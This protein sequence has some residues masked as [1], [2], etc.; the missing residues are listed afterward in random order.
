MGLW[1]SWVALLPQ[2]DTLMR[3]WIAMGWVHSS[4]DLGLAFSHIWESTRY[5]N[6]SRMALVV[7]KGVQ[8]NTQLSRSPGLEWHTVTS[9]IFYWL[10][11]S[12]SPD[13]FKGWENR[14]HLLMRRASM[15]P[16]KEYGH[17]EM[18]RTGKFGPQTATL[19]MV[20]NPS[21]SSKSTLHASI[22]IE[23]Q[24]AMQILFHGLPCS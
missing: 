5:Q 15:F 19:D 12:T 20:E 18:W 1:V 10:K 21:Y 2:L 16:C 22:I 14:L 7:E 4:V 13:Q 17:R 8:E 23:L 11:Q 24:P 3:P 6:L 9:T